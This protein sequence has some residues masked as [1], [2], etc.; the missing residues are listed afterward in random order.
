MTLYLTE[1]T[2][3]NDLIESFKN[4]LIFAV[5]LYPAGATTNSDSGVKDLK[6]SC[7]YLR[8]WQKLAYLFLFMVK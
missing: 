3:K 6:K 4:G 7:T 8:Q 1:N 5:K 2:N